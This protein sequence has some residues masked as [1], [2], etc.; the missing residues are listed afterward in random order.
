MLPELGE[1]VGGIVEGM[2][3]AGPDTLLATQQLSATNGLSIGLLARWADEEGFHL[4]ER[5]ETFGDDPY[6]ADYADNAH[7][8]MR[9]LSIR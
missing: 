5:E 8:M 6:W 4:F 1:I 3:L 2:T 7:W 9:V